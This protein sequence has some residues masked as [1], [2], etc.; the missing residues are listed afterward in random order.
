MIVMAVSTPH[1]AVYGTRAT[2]RARRMA[3]VSWRW[4]RA[5]LPEMRRGVIFPRSDTKLRSRRTSLKSTRS[6]LSTQNLQTLRRPNRRRFVGFPEG[7]MA[8]SS[9]SSVHPAH[10]RAGADQF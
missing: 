10:R 4:C 6:T 3:R 2:V 8:C 5:Q 7:G 1:S 9:C